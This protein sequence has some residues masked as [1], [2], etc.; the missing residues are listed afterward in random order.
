MGKKERQ[1]RGGAGEAWLGTVLAVRRKEKPLK[2]R[3]SSACWTPGSR[4]RCEHSVR[5]QSKTHSGKDGT[6]G[7][8]SSSAQPPAAGGDSQRCVLQTGRSPAVPP[9][10]GLHKLL[11]PP[12]PEKTQPH[13]GEGL[14]WGALTLCSLVT[15]GHL[16]TSH[17][18]L[19]QWEKQPEVVVSN[20][21][22]FVPSLRNE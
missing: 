14:G 13:P 5:T 15:Q 4:R 11:L 17:R 12:S 20:L 6:K 19:H 8:P 22:F 1:V 3:L 2:P 18:P 9:A 16:R 21:P 10:K 7:F